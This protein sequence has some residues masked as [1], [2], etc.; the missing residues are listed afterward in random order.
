MKKAIGPAAPVMVR[1][2]A[3]AGE[4]IGDYLSKNR[5]NLAAMH[6]EI[7][8]VRIDRTAGDASPE[9]GFRPILGCPT[10]RN[11]KCRRDVCP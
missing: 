9:K 2:K 5:F 8:A 1:W 4:L 11:N 7:G 10:T 3:K 6:P